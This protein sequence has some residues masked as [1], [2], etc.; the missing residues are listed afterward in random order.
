MHFVREILLRNVKYAAA[1]EGFIL[2]HIFATQKYFIIS[3]L[4]GMI[5]AQKAV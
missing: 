5:I 3:N 1:Y 4:C 2:F